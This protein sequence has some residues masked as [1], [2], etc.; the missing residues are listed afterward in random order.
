MCGATSGTT[1]IT[2]KCMHEQEEET[3][4]PSTLRRRRRR[5]RKETA[6]GCVPHPSSTL[7]RQKQKLGHE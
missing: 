6:K 1:G 7:A 2:Y 5:K 4:P 3:W